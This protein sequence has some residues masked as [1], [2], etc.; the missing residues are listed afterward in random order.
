MRFFL[1][2]SCLNDFF[3]LTV[4]S[5]TKKLYGVSNFPKKMHF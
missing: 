4:Q 5:Y 3:V 1:F 2:F